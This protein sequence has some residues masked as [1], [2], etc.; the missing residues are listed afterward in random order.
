MVYEIYVYIY[1]FLHVVYVIWYLS[2]GSH[3]LVPM[4]S[5]RG[6]PDIMFC[7]IL[8]F[9]WS[10]GALCTHVQRRAIIFED[11]LRTIDRPV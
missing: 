11:H 3:I 8:M 10:F 5:T 7:R 2:I 4:L 9:M 1:I 6:L